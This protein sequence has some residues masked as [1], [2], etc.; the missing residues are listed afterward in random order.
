ML[1]MGKIYKKTSNPKYRYCIAFISDMWW[2][3][4]FILLLLE[5]KVYICTLERKSFVYIIEW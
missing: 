5:I 4:L 2:N 1:R 3:D